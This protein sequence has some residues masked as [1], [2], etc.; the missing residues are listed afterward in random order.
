[1]SWLIREKCSPIF[2]INLGLWIAC[3]VKMWCK[4]FITHIILV[5][6]EGLWHLG[7]LL[8]HN[9]QYSQRWWYITNLLWCDISRKKA[10]CRGLR[11]TWYTYTLIH[12]ALS[13]A[14][15]RTQ[16]AAQL[17]WWFHWPVFVMATVKLQNIFWTGTWSSNR[18]GGGAILALSTFLN[19]IPH[20]KEPEISVGILSSRPLLT[21]TMVCLI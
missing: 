16:T 18:S 10:P 12:C 6:S 8:Y 7:S 4:Q 17:G 11:H 19:Q 20:Q 13:L 9:T 21:T 5:A 2:I 15:R 1:M 3:I 14:A